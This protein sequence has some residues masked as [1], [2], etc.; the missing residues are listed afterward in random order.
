[1]STRCKRGDLALVIRDTDAGKIVTCIEL[2]SARERL[3]SGVG[4]S[5]GQVWRIDRDCM[6]ADGRQEGREIPLPYCPDS[7]LVSIQPGPVE[8][9]EESAQSVGGVV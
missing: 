1:M 5:N 3:V 4:D 8:E 6:W 7:A 9:R 2:L